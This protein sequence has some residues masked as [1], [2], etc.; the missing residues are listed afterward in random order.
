MTTINAY[1]TFNGSCREAM[2][3]YKECLGGELNMQA[4]QD[5]P[6]AAQMP[7]AAQ[8]K[9]LHASLVCNGIELLATDMIGPAGYTNGNNIA[10]C[11]NCGSEN[12]VRTFFKNLSVGGN[13]THPLEDTFWSALFGMLTDKFGINW[14]FNYDKN[15]NNN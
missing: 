13:I 15:A 12:D 11:L 14:M 6:M 9:I 1:L 4:V 8:Q 7:A 5:S 2:T 10:L 3:F